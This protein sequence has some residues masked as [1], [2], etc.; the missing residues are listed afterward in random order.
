M[1]TARADTDSKIT[2]LKLGADAYLAK[3]FEREEL[4]VRIQKLIELRHA[5]INRYKSR[6]D[7]IPAQL[8]NES[9]FK[10]E[11]SF[12]KQVHEILIQNLDDEEFGIIE[13]S[14]SMGMSRSQLYRK[15]SALTEFT[16]H[17]FIKKLRLQKAKELLL[18]TN[19]NV[20]EV[21]LDTGF[22]NLSHFSK[23]F[24]E[25]F[26]ASP[27]HIKSANKAPARK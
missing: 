22:K 23:V 18:T 3:P 2:G 6:M 8:P 27:T 25:E 14:R 17:Q 12:I 1:L 11:D 16:V 4:F 19:L 10:K 7:N 21:A 24:Q 5:L 13:L 26:G 20:T 15:F 9:A